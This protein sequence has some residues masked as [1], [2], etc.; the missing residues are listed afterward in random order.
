MEE[1]FLKAFV[2]GQTRE[3]P[4]PWYNSAGDCIIYQMVD[5]AIVAERIDDILTIYRSAVDN[6][7]IG[8]QIK[9]VA[10]LARRYG[11]HGLLVKCG[12]DEEKLKEISLSWLLLVAYESGQKTIGR[13]QA[14]ADALESFASNPRARADE[15]EDPCNS[16]PKM[17]V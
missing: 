6:K 2:E 9:D 12:R 16:L 3:T 5:E 10:A 17:M 15:I 8:Y 11:W 7:P 14:Y 13:R 1:H 4:K